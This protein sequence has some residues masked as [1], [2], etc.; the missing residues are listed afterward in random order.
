M[1][2][3]GLDRLFRIEP[4]V[5]SRHP[6]VAQRAVRYYPVLRRI[7]VWALGVA[8]LVVLLQ[9]WGVPALGFFTHGRLGT[10]LLSALV[11]VLV[12]LLVGVLVWEGVN[13]AL[14]RQIDRFSDTNQAV[15]AARLQTLLPIL[16]T[17]L[18]VVLGAILMLTVLSEI[19]VNIAP[20]LAG[21]GIL[22]VAVG[23]GS[24]KLVQDFITGIFLLVENAMQ[25]GDT[26]TVAGISGTVEHLSIRTLRLRGGDGSIQIIPFSSVST[27]ANMSRDFA[28]ASISI[29]IAFSEDADRVCAMLGAVGAELRGD[30]GFASQ[31]LADFALNGIDSLGE[32]AVTISGTLRCTVAGRWPVQREFN[33]RLRARNRDA[34]STC[35]AC[36][37]WSTGRSLGRRSNTRT[38]A[39]ADPA[40]PEAALA[41]DGYAFVPAARMRALLGPE[42]LERWDQ[43]ASSWD[44]LGL[45]RYMADGGRYRR[46]RHAVFAAVR[47][48]I[49]RKPHQPH[50]QSRDYNALNG[51]IAR[52]FDPV[53]E[54][55]EQSPAFGAILRTCQ[56][57][58]DALSPGV[59][60]WEAEV[61]QFR[62][63]AQ[64]GQ[65]GQ[66]T[67][68][69]MHRDGVDWVRVLLV[70]RENIASG[71]TTIHDLDRRQLGAFT[72][73]RPMDA[74]WVDDS[75]VYHG[76]T[77][78]EPR[79]P[80]RP[81]QLSA[82]Q[83]SVTRNHCLSI[84]LCL[85]HLCSG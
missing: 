70:R 83:H 31:I 65:S 15:R 19:G 21:A 35:R 27:V 49:T 18:F 74:A 2:L 68:E 59:P 39:M 36:P 67:P 63:E 22:G 73:A 17:L 57:V 41:A 62:I 46:R 14:D 84:H 71:E 12:T 34:P 29:A 81:A 52:W 53:T 85:V 30:D 26:V 11:T 5:T 51:G 77:P 54:A 8:G 6:G 33:R 40:A 61:H 23:F 43:F 42:A 75:R 76:V 7:V 16:R 69:G 58:F 47:E 38:R 28:V 3:G 66:P 82:A 56:R 9:W 20:L 72:L 80:A 24:Q 55:T 10:R 25:V 64:P 79:D 1:L 13:G 45:D 44:H 48:G 37:A 32:Y 50:Y 60:E 78:V 4:G